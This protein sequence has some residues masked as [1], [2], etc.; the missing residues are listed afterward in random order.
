MANVGSVGILKHIDDP[1][2]TV[3]ADA[4]AAGVTWVS[5]STG[6]GT[7]FVKAVAAGKGLHYAGALTAVDNELEEFNGN[8]LQFAAQEGH[9]SVEIIVQFSTI[10]DLAFCFGFNDVAE[11]G[12]MPMELTGTTISANAGTFVGLLYD[13]DSTDPDNLYCVWVDGDTVGQ[14]DSTGS[15]NGQAIKMSGIAPTAAQWFYMKVSMQ[16]RGSGNG[17]RVT[18][19]ATDHLGRSVEKVFNTTVTRSTPLCF[20]YAVENR[21]ATARNLYIRFPNWEQDTPDM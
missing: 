11:E 20:S 12:N 21:D 5:D 14:T 10:A 19:M 15:V 1:S 9:S 3:I 16:D 7:D 18:F 13:D 4:S 6:S 17:A 8:N 2:V